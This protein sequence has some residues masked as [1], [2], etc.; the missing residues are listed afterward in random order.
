MI[1]SRSMAMQ[2]GEPY[3]PSLHYIPDD[4]QW[5]EGLKAALGMDDLF[6]YAHFETGGWFL[7]K[8]KERPPLEGWPGGLIINLK[9]LGGNPDYG[10]C[11]QGGT[12]GLPS[13]QEV[14]SLT[15][16]Q[17]KVFERVRKMLF[18][19]QW[20]KEEQEEKNRREKASVIKHLR[21][22]AGVHKE[23]H[24]RYDRLAIEPMHFD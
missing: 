23:D 20:A 10:F 22:T 3:D 8:W 16:T 18:E 4:C 19:R 9:E 24:P 5:V 21:K 6:V 11:P 1:E 12:I 14:V 2:T 7:A 17:E 13:L 15:V